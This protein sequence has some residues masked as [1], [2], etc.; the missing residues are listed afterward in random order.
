MRKAGGHIVRGLKAAGRLYRTHDLVR[1]L[2]DGQLQFVGRADSQIKIR[3]FRVELGEIESVLLEA[4]EI[5]QAAVKTVESDGLLEIAAHIVLAPGQTQLDRAALGKLLSQRFPDYMIPKYVDILDELPTMTSGKVDRKLLPPPQHLLHDVSDHQMAKAESDLEVSL[6]DACQR[7][8]HLPAISIDHD[9]CTDLHGH[10]LLAARVVTDFRNSVPDVPVSVRDFYEFRTLRKL[11]AALT[12]R[13]VSRTRSGISMTGGQSQSAADFAPLPRTP[14]F[15][16]CCEHSACWR[17]PAWFSLPAACAVMLILGVRDGH[18]I[19]QQ[20]DAD[21]DHRR[22]RVWPSWLLLS[23]AVKWLVVGRFESGR[24]PVMGLLLFS[25]WLVTRFQS[26]SWSEMFID[27]PLMSLYYRA[28]GAKVGSNVNI[29]TPVCAA[30][31]LVSI[32]DNTS[33]GS[34]THLLGYKVENGWLVL[35]PIT[36]GR[37]CCIGTHCSSLA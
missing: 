28:M 17:S 19:W 14:G 15:A 33:I 7:I 27:T 11:A 9:F 18:L 31:D 21:R 2:D 24:Y 12:E 29:G 16:F 6:V 37:D 4:D 25:L 36:I 32:G 5:R 26:L 22:L 10:S 3:G 1:L 8:L 13:R 34:E 30:F 23:I 35:G 20:A